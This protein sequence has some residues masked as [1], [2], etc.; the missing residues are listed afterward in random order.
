MKVNQDQLIFAVA[1]TRA[2][3]SRS[4]NTHILRQKL[5][6]TYLQS[7]FKYSVCHVK[8]WQ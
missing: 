7:A 1:Q 3:L 2:E 4:P 6:D 8:Y 5:S